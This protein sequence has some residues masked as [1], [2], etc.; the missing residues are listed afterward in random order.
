MTTNVNTT[1]ELLARLLGQ[2][3]IKENT[4]LVQTVTNGSTG[5]KVAT[6]PMAYHAS[7]TYTTSPSF[8]HPYMGPT[9]YIQQPVCTLTGPPGSVSQLPLVKSTQHM[10][11]NILL[12]TQHISHVGQPQLSLDMWGPRLFQDKRSHYHMLFM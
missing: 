9:D 8:V 1:N 10:G 7:P 11:P 3:G 4:N 6:V 12:Y 2:L 5:N